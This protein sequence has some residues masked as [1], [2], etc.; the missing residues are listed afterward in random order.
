MGHSIFWPDVNKETLLLEEFINS[1]FLEEQSDPGL[2]YLPNREQS[3]QGLHWPFRLHRI[4]SMVEPHSSNFRVITK[5]LFG[6][7]NI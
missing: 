4:N 3:D 7:P 1:N 6:F 5:K 2:H